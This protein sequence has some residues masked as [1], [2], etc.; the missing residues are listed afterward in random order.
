MFPFLDIKQ[1]IDSQKTMLE[2]KMAGK[3]FPSQTSNL[4]AIFPLT[5]TAPLC[6]SVGDIMISNH[7]DC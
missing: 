3:L 5:L 6:F 1:M 4:I 7:T 2:L